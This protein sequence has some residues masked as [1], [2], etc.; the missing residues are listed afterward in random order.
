[1]N[2]TIEQLV[3][4]AKE[5]ETR[6]PIEWGEIPVNEDLV[7]NTFAVAM[8]SAYQR[9]SVDNKDLVLLASIIKLQAE[10]FAL[11]QHNKILLDTI[12]RLKNTG[13]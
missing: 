1:M 2:I 3:E 13:E 5:A 7:Y 4:L 10:S 11:N 12:R 6:N 9:I 8:L